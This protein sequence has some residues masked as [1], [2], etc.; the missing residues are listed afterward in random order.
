MSVLEGP[1]GRIVFS[2]GWTCGEDEVV[3]LPLCTPT[4]IICVHVNYVSR[5]FEFNDSRTPARSRATSAAR[6]PATALRASRRRTTSAATTSAI[7]MPARCC[8]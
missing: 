1:H 7:P 3:H 5:Y 8:G 6:R 4:K 2:D